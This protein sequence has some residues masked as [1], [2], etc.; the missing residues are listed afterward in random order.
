MKRKSWK[1]CK[2]SVL[3]VLSIVL[4]FPFSGWAQKSNKEDK[5]QL[6]GFEVFFSGGLYFA[7]KNTASFYNGSPENTMNLGLIFNNEYVFDRVTEL[8]KLNHGYVSTIALGALPDIMSYGPAMSVQLGFKYRFK[9]NWS[10]G[11]NYSFARVKT[12]G[13][14]IID[15]PG[16]PP[17]NVYLT[18]T[19]GALVAEEERSTI[20]MSVGYTM[21]NHTIAKPFFEIGAQ[22][23]YM[24]IRNF[25]AVIEGTTFSLMSER[26]NPTNPG[27]QGIPYNYVWGGSGYGFSASFGVK[28][29]ASPSI[30]IDPV[31][32]LSANSLGYG[33]LLTTYDHGFY[34]NYAAM[35][36][37]TISDAA[38]FKN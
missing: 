3:I 9:E 8:V 5:W 30:S 34:F 31:F 6:D 1:I 37:L 7:N 19:T 20:E 36:R 21:H 25:D 23:N 10:F 4:A 35:I 26:E 18:Y 29:A 38:F 33:R 28:I 12:V 32:T 22:F 27:V 17:S 2:N 14:F 24:K 13:E 11:M 15:F 16:L